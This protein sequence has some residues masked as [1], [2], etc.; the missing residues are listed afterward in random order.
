MIALNKPLC[1]LIAF[2]LSAQKVNTQ[3]LRASLIPNL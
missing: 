1:F 3:Y 2:I